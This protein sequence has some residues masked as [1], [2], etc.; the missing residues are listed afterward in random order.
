M[1]KRKSRK[2]SKKSQ[3]PW[4]SWVIGILFL[5]L[6]YSIY[7][8]K[9]P[10]QSITDLYR[11]IL[12]KEQLYMSPKQKDAAV[13]VYTDSINA[14]NIFIR[15]QA[16]FTPFRKAIVNTENNSLNLRLESNITSEVVIKIPDSSIVEVIYFDEEIFVLEGEPGKWCKIRYADKEGWVWGNYV[17]ILE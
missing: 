17:T 14:L 16:E 12:G 2:R 13:K 3:F 9:S 5:W 4:W 15:K 11:N 1:T 6:C 10:T 8:G 7:D